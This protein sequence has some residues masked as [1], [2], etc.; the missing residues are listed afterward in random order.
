MG[1][2]WLTCR[3][4]GETFPDCGHFVNCECGEHWCSEECAE[5]DGFEE[6]HCKLGKSKDDDCDLEISCWRCENNVERSCKYCREEDF[7]DEVLLTYT[8]NLLN[9]SREQLI[10]KYK[11]SK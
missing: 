5:T 4:C 2:D 11:F 1:V 3:N 8:L 9:L 10:E 7:S 6:E